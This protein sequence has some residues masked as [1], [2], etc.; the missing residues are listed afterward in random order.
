MD[1]IY[2]SYLMPWFHDKSGSSDCTG[3]S[4]GSPGPFGRAG[5]TLVELVIAV[6]IV[7]VLTA[8][9]VPSYSGYRDRVR[10]AQAKSDIIGLGPAI[11]QYRLNND[12]FPDSL[13]DVGN[14]GM[15]DPWKHPYEYLNLSSGA[16]GVAG[17]RRKDKNLV[18]I[19]SDYDLYSMGKDGQSQAPLTAMHSRDDIVRASDGRFVGLASDY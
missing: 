3:R 11:E 9:A 14:G 12:R 4:F 1:S 18:P 8:I 10:V 15:L 2:S 6:A 16:P 17:K 13:A 7:A 19:N 5:F